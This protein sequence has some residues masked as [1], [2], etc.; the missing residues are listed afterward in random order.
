[1]H[2]DDD[3]D[4]DQ[5]DGPDSLNEEEDPDQWFTDKSVEGPAVVTFMSRGDWRLS[6]GGATVFTFTLSDV[7]SG[8][9]F[10]PPG[11]LFAG[12]GHNCFVS[13]YRF[14]TDDDDDD[15]DE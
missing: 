11:H 12:A 13:G 14:Y 6:K 2:D 15:A 7:K 5:Y 3:D 8:K 9:L 4:D 1:M 10:V